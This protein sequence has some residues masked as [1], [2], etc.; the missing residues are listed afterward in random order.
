MLRAHWSEKNPPGAPTPSVT[1]QEIKVWTL[2]KPSEKEAEVGVW[3]GYIR[4]GGY[5]FRD[6]KARRQCPFLLMVKVEWRQSRGLSSK[7]GKM[8]TVL[9]M[10]WRWE[11]ER[12][13]WILNF[14]FGWLRSGGKFRLGGLHVK[15]LVRNLGTSWVQTGSRWPV[16]GPLGCLPTSA[17]QSGVQTHESK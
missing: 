6:V 8:W 13:D 12:L 2:W 9:N 14:V 1:S 7:E 10:Q 16:A 3:W 4:G 5:K 15:F 17:H 11:F